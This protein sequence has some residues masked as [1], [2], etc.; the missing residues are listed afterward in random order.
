MVRK[1]LA[2]ASNCSRSPQETRM[3]LVWVL[4]AGFADAAVQR[5]RSS[6]CAGKLLGVADLFDPVA[7]V[8]GEYDGVDHKGGERHRS[9]VAREDRM[10]RHGLE[11]FTVVGGDLND[12]ELVT[13]RMQRVSRPSAFAPPEHR[14]WTLTPPPWWRPAR[15]SWIYT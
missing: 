13:A 11:Y 6:T 9:D 5:R 2:L 12:R 3:R 15:K 4:D 10:R 1:S 14:A 8:V 7:G